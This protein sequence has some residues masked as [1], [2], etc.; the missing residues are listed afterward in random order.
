MWNYMQYPVVIFIHKVTIL[1][2]NIKVELMA[3]NIEQFKVLVQDDR[4]SLA[5]YSQNNGPKSIQP[6]DD[7]VQCTV[8]TREVQNFF[9]Q[10]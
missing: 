6:K 2:D 8:Y 4:R 3:D 7:F 9:L 5:I 1:G 10:Q